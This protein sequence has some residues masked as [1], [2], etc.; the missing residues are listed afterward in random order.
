MVINVTF[1]VIGKTD[2]YYPELLFWSKERIMCSVSE[3][4]GSERACSTSLILTEDDFWKDN[5]IGPQ[6][7]KNTGQNGWFGEKIYSKFWK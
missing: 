5:I 7:E 1:I 6:S 2:T 3:F 4:M